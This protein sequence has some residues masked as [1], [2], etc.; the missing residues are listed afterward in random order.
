[1]N[2]PDAGKGRGKM[3]EQDDEIKEKHL[4]HI[5]EL[6]ETPD[7]DFEEIKRQTEAITEAELDK[8][9]AKFVIKTTRPTVKQEKMVKSIND[10]ADYWRDE[11]GV[12][13]IPADTQNK[14]PLVAWKQYENHPVSDEQHNEWKANDMFSNG[15]AI[16]PGKVLHN[17][18]K[19]DLYLICVDLDNQKAI[20]EFCTR[21]GVITPPKRI[22]Q[23]RNSRTA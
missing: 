2:R 19:K 11:V 7:F 10:W 23:I 12:N 5:A 8:D 18:A 4:K 16:I 22:G 14:K 1:M 21:N 20:D 9:Y 3:T 6:R 13:V 15:L 17:S